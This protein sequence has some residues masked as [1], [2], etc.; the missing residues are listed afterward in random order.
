MIN[1]MF[2]V[3]NGCQNWHRSELFIVLLYLS[4]RSLFSDLR[5]TVINVTL[6]TQ[7]HFA[8]LVVI[9]NEI[10]LHKKRLNLRDRFTFNWQM[11]IIF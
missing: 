10:S 7:G 3:V 5:I 4:A 9:Q 2:H 8:F 1:F 11:A 6:I